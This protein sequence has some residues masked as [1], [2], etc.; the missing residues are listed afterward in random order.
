MEWNLPDDVA[1]EQIDWH[2]EPRDED[3]PEED[4]VI[5]AVCLSCGGGGDSMNAPGACWR[6]GGSGR[7]DYEDAS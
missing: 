3:I 5:D 6:C 4:Y 1:E 7:M 2:L